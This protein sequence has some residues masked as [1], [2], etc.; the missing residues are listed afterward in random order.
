MNNTHRNSIYSNI[1]SLKYKVCPTIL[2]KGP[3]QRAVGRSAEATEATL[4]PAAFAYSNVATVGCS[5]VPY[6][7]YEPVREAS[8]TAAVFTPCCL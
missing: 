2:H 1:Y 6:S 3:A 5:V 8:T 4:P 7:S